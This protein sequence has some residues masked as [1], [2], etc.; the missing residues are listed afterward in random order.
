MRG[1][2]REEKVS[3]D[4]RGELAGWPRAGGGARSEGRSQDSALNSRPCVSSHS[5][6]HLLIHISF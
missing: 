5:S 4:W 1:A 3:R 2:R 6:T